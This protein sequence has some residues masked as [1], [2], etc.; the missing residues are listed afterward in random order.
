MIEI[1]KNI[2]ETDGRYSVSNF[3][4]VKRNKIT[5]VYKDGR[6]Y[7]LPERELKL[8][9]NNWG[10]LCV[11]YRLNGKYVRRCVHVLVAKAFV[12]NLHGKGEVNHKDGNRQN[13]V[14]SNLEWVTH[15]ENIRHAYYI[16]NKRFS[17]MKPKKVRCVETGETFNSFN[18]AAKRVK[19]NVVCICDAV[20]GKQ[21]TCAGYHWALEEIIGEAVERM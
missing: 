14:V 1:W 8:Q 12:P 16:L 10:Y 19:R 3:G 11:N 7:T 21:K 9:P 4:H 2:V 13:N 6:E 20:S 18:E 15:E 17:K 5:Q